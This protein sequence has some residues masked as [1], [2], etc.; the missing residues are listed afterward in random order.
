MIDPEKLVYILFTGMIIF[1]AFILVSSFKGIYSIIAMIF[2]LI[3]AIFVF[4]IGL[5]DSIVFPILMSTLGITFQIAKDYKISRSQKEILKNVNGLNYATGYVTANL[6]PYTF[7]LESVPGE[8]ES[9]FINAPVNWERAVS[10]LNFPWKYHI[11]SSGMDVQ[12]TREEFEGQRSF[13]EFQMSRAMQSTTPNEMAVE[14]LQRKINMIQA[15][16]D[17][18]SQGERP[19][20]TLMYIEVTAVG[21]SEKSAIDNLNA[22]I[23]SISTAFSSFDV[24]LNRISGRELYVLFKTNFAL[25][26]TFA[27][28]AADFDQQS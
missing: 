1:L 2:I 24:Q 20:A 12:E 17:R 16:M 9:K 10:T 3:A 19:I 26:T 18:I 11:I 21:V 15:K 27:E 7:K 6:F 25:P 14:Q 8:E 13:Q 23:A 5:A 22:Q 4:S 28:V